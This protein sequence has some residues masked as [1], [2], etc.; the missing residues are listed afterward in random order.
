[1]TI[2]IETRLGDLDGVPVLAVTDSAGSN[3]IIGGHQHKIHYLS[4]NY[5]SHD[6]AIL[7]GRAVLTI[8]RVPEEYTDMKD[9]KAGMARSME[10][11]L[12]IS[13]IHHKTMKETS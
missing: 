1:M 2:P 8:G 3:V 11:L 13:S 6:T 4:P 10:N 5:T 7:C 12:L 9:E